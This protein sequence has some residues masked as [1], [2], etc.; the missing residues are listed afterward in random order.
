VDG[1]GQFPEFEK[2]LKKGIPSIYHE[3]VIHIQELFIGMV[4][5]SFGFI[6]SFLFSHVSNLVPAIGLL[7]MIIGIALILNGTLK[8]VSRRRQYRFQNLSRKTISESIM[9]LDARAFPSKRLESDVPYDLVLHPSFYNPQKFRKVFRSF[10]I[11]T[12]GQ[13]T[14]PSSILDEF[15]WDAKEAKDGFRPCSVTFFGLTIIFLVIIVYILSLAGWVLML[16]TV[17]LGY[18]V[19]QGTYMY[20]RY[21]F[22]NKSLFMDSWIDELVASESVEL[23]ESI[24]QIFNLLQ[25]KFPYPFRFY[26]RGEYPQL[27]YTGREVTSPD[28]IRLKEAL[29]YPILTV[30]NK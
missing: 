16:T 5:A 17:V 24:H 30:D 8:Y 10:A 4:I 2:L 9:Y 14:W 21:L 1:E 23:E 20:L 18:C 11:S 26:I 13:I 28:K 12:R 19:L 15:R 27:V 22:D 6:L 29:L 3:E 25:A 7:V